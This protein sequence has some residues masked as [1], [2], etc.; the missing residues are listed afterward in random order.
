MPSRKTRGS[1]LAPHPAPGNSA[2]LIL[3]LISDW[4]FPDAEKLLPHALAIAPTVAAFKARCRSAR[5][6]VIYG[7][8]N[9][10]QWRSDFRQVVETSLASGGSGAR[11]T[12]LLAPHDDDY[13]VLKPKHS[14][15]FGTPLDL[16]L[17]YLG[18]RRLFVAGVASDQCV[19]ATAMDARMR[20]YEVVVVSDS[21]ASQSR[22]RNRRALEHFDKLAIAT[23]P[24]AHIRLP[25]ARR[26]A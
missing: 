24:A 19:V 17:Q 21:V 22:A 23:M 26:R 12:A 25:K 20:D 8:D 18:V 9:Q 10:G 14:A 13:F 16:L 11:V 5:V 1:S 4:R 7:N 2:L 15:F 6:P 3:D